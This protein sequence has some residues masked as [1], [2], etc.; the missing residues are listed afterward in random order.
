MIKRESKTYLILG[1]AGFIGSHFCD[2]ILKKGDNV[3]CVDN[4]SLGSE[5]NIQH[6]MN[7]SNFKFLELD[8][9]NLTNSHFSEDHIDTVIHLA[10]NS[11]IAKSFENP[12]IDISNTLNTTLKTL[13]FMKSRS[14]KELI[15]ASSS[16][17]YGEHDG[18]I[19][20]DI[21]PL[22]PHS[23]YGAAKLASEAFISSYSENYGLK[24]WIMRFPNV[25]GERCTHGVIFDF[26]QK[27]NQNRDLLR[28]L[29]DGN[30][31]KPYLYVHELING[32]MHCFENL[33]NRINYVNLGTETSTTVN[34][35]IEIF[36]EVLNINPV[37]EYSGGTKGWIGDIPKFSYDLSK[38]HSYGWRAKLTSNEAVYETLKALSASWIQ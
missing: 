4:L 14:I 11:D 20:E 30:Q 32:I 17:I 10:A 3:I 26:F 25:I 34:Q 35:I 28:V 6:L 5:K 27:L 18:L 22:F 33:S 29:G 36:K 12:L 8:I 31:D 19:H 21:G 2:Y 37:I 16:A 24:A 1:G 13:D 9:N 15:F 7:R 38:V 23:H